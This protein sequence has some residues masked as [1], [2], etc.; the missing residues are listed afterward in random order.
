M[1]GEA[2]L[3]VSCPADLQLT[4]QDMRFVEEYC[5]DL[6]HGR[7]AVAAGWPKSHGLQALDRAD[8][9]EMVTRRLTKISK[10]SGLSAEW[11][12]RQLR[13][14][15]ERCMQAKPVMKKVGNTYVETGE[16]EF[17]SG[18]ANKA[19]EILAKHLGM[20]KE[21]VTITVEH[22]LTQMSQAELA[23]RVAS[24]L[25][26]RKLLDATLQ[27]PVTELLENTEGVF[28]EAPA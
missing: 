3:A 18:G 17:D 2:R 4:E 15:V 5:V 22:E 7:A 13:E 28:E 6:D 27:P 11:V 9:Q 8:M 19:L 25:E 23:K 10:Q 16:W 21:N 12:R 14:V 24:I 1:G 26:E 20:L